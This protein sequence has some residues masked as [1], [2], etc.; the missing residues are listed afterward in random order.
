[1]RA[2][3]GLS[4][5]R[6]LMDFET[7]FQIGQPTAKKAAV[8][9]QMNL[10]AAADVLPATFFQPKRCLV[11]EFADAPRDTIPELIQPFSGL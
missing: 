5:N 1:M 3:G 9:M 4:L 11:R 7:E 8:L 2:E 6:I 10:I